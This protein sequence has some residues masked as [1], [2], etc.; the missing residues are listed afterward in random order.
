MAQTLILQHGESRLF[1]MHFTSNL[2]SGET[3][4]SITS[5]T[6]A[7]T[8]LTISGNAI[9]TLGKKIQFS[10]TSTTPNSY[11]VTGKVVTSTGNTLEGEGILLVK[12]L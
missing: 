5:V 6:A 12:D 7:P 11:K 9:A 1:T 3:I 10:I 8:G 2:A 4:A